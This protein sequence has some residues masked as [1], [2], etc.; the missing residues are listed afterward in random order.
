M[1][2]YF[3]LLIAVAVGVIGFI[4]GRMTEVQVE[5]ANG[6]AVGGKFVASADGKTATLKA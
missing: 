4:A 6:K 1:K 5:D 3:I 2:W